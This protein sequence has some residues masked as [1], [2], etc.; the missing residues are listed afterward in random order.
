MIVREAGL[1]ETV[2]DLRHPLISASL[3]SGRC[4]SALANLAALATLI[5]LGLYTLG[6]TGRAFVPQTLGAFRGGFGSGFVAPSAFVVITGG[7]DDKGERQR[8]E[9]NKSR[10]SH[11]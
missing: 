2:L 7:T 11:V 5:A 1:A 3:R 9:G 4:V 10:G 8:G 6:T